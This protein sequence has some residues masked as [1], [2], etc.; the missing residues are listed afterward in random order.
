LIKSVCDDPVPEPV[1]PCNRQCG[2]S[3]V[4][5]FCRGCFR[6]LDEIAKWDRMEKDEQI[7]VLRLVEERKKK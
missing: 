1:D 2:V 4:T 7:E 5:G 3:S 6:K